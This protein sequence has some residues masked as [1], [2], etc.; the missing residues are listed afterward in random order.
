[1]SV[2]TPT[3][4][5]SYPSTQGSYFTFKYSTR[6]PKIEADDSVFVLWRQP[7]KTDEVCDTQNTLIAGGLAVH[8]QRSLVLY[9]CLLCVVHWSNY[10]LFFLAGILIFAALLIQRA[11]VAIIPNA[12]DACPITCLQVC[13]RALDLYHS[14]SRYSLPVLFLNGKNMHCCV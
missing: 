5:P 7:H 8:R 1:M 9:A 2:R 12:V 3:R 13:F 11:L 6:I 14:K 10:F 4:S